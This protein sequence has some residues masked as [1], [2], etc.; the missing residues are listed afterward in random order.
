MRTGL[1][2][3]LLGL[4]LWCGCT[5]I[6]LG[7]SACASAGGECAP[8]PGGCPCG[9]WSPSAACESAGGVSRGCCL[10][11][12]CA[13]GDMGPPVCVANGG[14]CSHN[15][16]CCSNDCPQLGS[17]ISVCSGG[18][19]MDP[20]AAAGG[21]CVANAIDCPRGHIGDL[22]GFGDGSGV[23][24]HC[25]LPGPEAVPCGNMTCGTNQVCIEPCY[26]ELGCVP[27]AGDGSC[28]PGTAPPT[29]GC[30]DAN[31]SPGCAATSPPTCVSLPA[32]CDLT[33]Q[34]SACSCFST[35]PCSLGH[36]SGSQT[37]GA[38]SCFCNPTCAPATVDAFVASHKSCV[39]N[40]D[41]TPICSLGAS[42]DSRA[43]NQA[44]AAAFASTFANCTFQQCAVSCPAA[45]CDST[46][47]C[48]P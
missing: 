11:G 3:A 44:G 7:A 1:G 40:Q 32:S 43:V 39:S 41:C 28:P 25:C 46:G 2:A 22:C 19:G 12:S 33:S 26:A 47:S 6:N 16:D 42:C 37:P 24:G 31:G 30:S 45:T 8:F 29:P 17:D 5:S 38:I 27:K 20:C 15:S 10:P 36:C 9:Q 23:A 4:T 48:A 14:R 34:A 13:S 35:D 21:T 18:G